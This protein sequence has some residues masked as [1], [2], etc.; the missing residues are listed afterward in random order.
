MI[1]QLYATRIS[2]EI[3]VIMSSQGFG[4]RMTLESRESPPACRTFFFSSFTS[5][6]LA[7]GKP[8][9]FEGITQN[10]GPRECCDGNLRLFHLNNPSA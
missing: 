6:R 10:Y 4:P 7:L 1:K 8:G 3:K 5:S 2:I 9:I